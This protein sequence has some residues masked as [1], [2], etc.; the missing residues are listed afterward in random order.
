M[1]ASLTTFFHVSYQ[2]GALGNQADDLL[3]QLAKVAAAF[4]G[5][6]LWR[7]VEGLQNVHAAV[8]QSFEAHLELFWVERWHLGCVHGHRSQDL[9]VALVHQGLQKVERRRHVLYSRRAALELQL[10]AF[11]AAV[12]G[13]AQRGVVYL[14]TFS[15]ARFLGGEIL[16]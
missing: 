2:L 5:R 14:A 8:N 1:L 11:V 13:W 12:G 9:L 3:V 15:K 10:G 16:V 7:R 4:G 6:P